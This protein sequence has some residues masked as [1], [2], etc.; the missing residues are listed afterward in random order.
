M[1]Y[2]ALGKFRQKRIDK[3]MRLKHL[4]SLLAG[5]ALI[6]ACSAPKN[7]TYFQDILAG[8]STDVMPESQI[9]LRPEDKISIVVNCNDPKI[10]NLFNLPYTTQR[11]GATSESTS[12][13]GQGV[14]GYTLDGNGNIDFPVLGTLHI[15][16][17]RREEVAA[18]VKDQ[19]ISRELTKEAVVTVEFMNLSVSVLGEVARPGRYNITRDN[20]TLFDAL[21]SAGDLTIQAKRDGVIV[22]REEGG[23]QKK[24]VVNMCSAQEVLQS[25]VYYLQQNDMVYVEPNDVRARQSTL[26]GNSVLSS[27]FWVSIASLLSTY[28]LFFLKK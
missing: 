16:G 23:Q 1:P 8:E 3:K 14:S 12:S 2:K 19:L 26:N 9:R 27:S 6:A 10:T 18:Y 25:P 4:I 15:G 5:A 11:L 22:L 13:Y 21:S 7:I 20:F 28:I 24:Y 17:M